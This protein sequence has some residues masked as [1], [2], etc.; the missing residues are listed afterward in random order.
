[1]DLIIKGID[2][3]FYTKNISTKHAKNH[4]QLT[5][6]LKGNKKYVDSYLLNK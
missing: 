1:M 3:F 4:E 5:S 2:K 6:I